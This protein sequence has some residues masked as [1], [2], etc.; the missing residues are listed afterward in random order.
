MSIDSK[1]GRKFV[2]TEFMPTVPEFETAQ[3]VPL[4][5]E[6]VEILDNRL[7]VLTERIALLEKKLQSVMLSTRTPTEMKDNVE[8]SVDELY[9]PLAEELIHLRR[10]VDEQ[11]YL[12][13]SLLDRL[14]I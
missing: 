3:R 1:A 9:V 8:N 11:I 6:A 12:L 4:V 7:Q 13:E 10:N 2:S 5:Q 14:E